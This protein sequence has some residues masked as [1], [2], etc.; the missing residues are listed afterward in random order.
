MLRKFFVLA[1]ALLAFAVLPAAASA[2]APPSFVG[3][4]LHGPGVVLPCD[5]VSQTATGP[6]SVSGAADGP[7]P[8][9]FTETGVYGQD[10]TTGDQ[11]FTASFTI[12]ADDGT[13]I[14]GTKS[15]PGPG[16]SLIHPFAL[17]TAEVRR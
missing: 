8:G 2:L 3:E 6:F 7:Y 14:T 11:T 5:L 10:P 13:V 9:T 17:L 4:T 15:Y 1:F 12:N 16:T